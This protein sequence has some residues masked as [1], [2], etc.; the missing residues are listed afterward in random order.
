[1]KRLFSG[2]LRCWECGARDRSP[3]VYSSYGD[4]AEGFPSCTA[5]YEKADVCR[6]Y[7]RLRTCI[8]SAAA[9]GVTDDDIAVR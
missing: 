4:R 3:L 8:T 9:W 7:E 1:M 5:L 2:A 6:L